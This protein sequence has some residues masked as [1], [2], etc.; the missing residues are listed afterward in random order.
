MKKSHHPLP[1]SIRRAATVAL[2]APLMALALVAL[3][4]GGSGGGKSA[5]ATPAA[6]QV[7]ATP[8]ATAAPSATPEV[9]LP[10]PGAQD[11]DRI[12]ISKIGVKAP[13][14]IHKVGADGQMP[15]PNGPDDIAY[16]DFDSALWPGLGGAPGSGGNVILAGHV[17]WGVQHGVGCKNNTVAAPCQAVLWDLSKLNKGDE[18]EIDVGDKAYKYQITGSKSYSASYSG[19]NDVFGPQGQEALTIVTCSGDFN[20]VTKE[21]GSRLVVTAIRV[22]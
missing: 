8:E 6:S 15:N 2:A 20:P 21:Y 17:D 16:Y 12:V 4:C 3:A 1:L 22:A 10:L 9:V 13:L 18:L 19:W 11:T 5:T 14:S 7:A